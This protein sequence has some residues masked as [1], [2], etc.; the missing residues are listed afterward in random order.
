M[1][2]Y[3]PIFIDL[4]GKQARVFGG[5]A[6]ATRRVSALLEFGAEVHVAAPEISKALVDL[7]EGQRKLTLEQRPYRQGEL[8]E[9]DMVLAIT[10][11]EAVNNMIFQECR[12]KNILVNVASDRSKCDFYFPGIAREGEI[13]VGGTAGGR[14]HK[15]AAEVTKGI[16]ELLKTL[17]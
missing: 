7:A 3:F 16:R 10:D 12:Q 15:K 8:Q 9:E 1:G 13:T 14:D 11:D 17:L 5:G 2:A 6:I 4:E